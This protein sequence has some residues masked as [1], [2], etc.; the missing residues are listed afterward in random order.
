MSNVAFV[1]TKLV[2]LLV[3]SKDIHLYYHFIQ[4]KNPHKTRHLDLSMEK[5]VGKD[6]IRL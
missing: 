3:L 4:I 5:T 6:R 2:A 1:G